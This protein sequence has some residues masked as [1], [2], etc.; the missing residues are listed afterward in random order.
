[1]CVSNSIHLV[2][3]LF[4]SERLGFRNWKTSDIDKMAEINANKQVMEFF[5]STQTAEQT[6]LFIERMQQ[7]LA[8]TGFCYFAVDA[9]EDGKLI[10]FIGMA[11]QTFDAAFT[12][13]IDI[14]WRLHPD[15]W[16]KGYA[17]ECAKACL[18]YAFHTLKLKKVYAMAP[19]IN[20][21][22]IAVMQKIGMHYVTN[23]MHPLLLS[24]ERL[25]DCVLYEINN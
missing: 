20:Q 21:K 9:L 3:Y 25:K 14:G 18:E 19:A 17:T 6:A 16:G 2:D 8:R 15:V 7:L 12:P 13:C 5:P 11:E 23:F 4:T 24:D 10:G 22:S 1:M